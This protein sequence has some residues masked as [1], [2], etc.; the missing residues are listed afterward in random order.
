MTTL[1]DT[2]PDVDIIV[3][4]TVDTTAIAAEDLRIVT[5]MTKT[6]SVTLL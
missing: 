6:H 5:V 3:T 4:D 2:N 1:G